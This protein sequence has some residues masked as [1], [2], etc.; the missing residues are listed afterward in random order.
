[1]TDKQETRVD[2]YKKWFLNHKIY[3]LIIIFGIVIIALGA[4]SENIWKIIDSSKR[5][6]KNEETIKSVSHTIN[7]EIKITKVRPIIDQPTQ[8][9]NFAGT[10]ILSL[11]WELL[12]SNNGDK[13]LSVID[14]EVLQG[15][16]S[17]TDLYQGLYILQDATLQAINFPIIIPAGH[18][19]PLFLRLGVIIDKKVFAMI[20]EEFD[21]KQGQN[22][23][24]IIDFLRSREIDVYGNPFTK[25]DIGVYS[26]PPLDEIR[27]PV[28]V[29]KFKTARN[30]QIIDSISWYKYGL[31]RLATE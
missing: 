17:Y 22:A 31:Y 26:L 12:L 27:D 11:H 23:S 21:G 9:R 25:S 15:L 19:Y 30:T 2:F 10:G 5:F 7:D 29:V 28:F 4:F 6:V 1:M 18:S 20:K 14:C 24:S 3:S 8:I 13:D 16:I